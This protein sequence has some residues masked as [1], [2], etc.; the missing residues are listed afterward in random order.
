MF[1][2]FKQF[3]VETNAVAL[4]IA[5]VLGAAVA[6]LVTSL[7]D[8]L[9][10]PLLSLVLPGGDWRHWKLVMV[11]GTPG[12]D[13]TMVGEKAILTGQILGSALDFLIIAMIVY[14]VAVKLLK[15]ELK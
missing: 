9:I 12:P 13:G 8:G 3:L 15:I 10:M 5:V 2:K 11:H 1:E 14:M 7:T 6:K 4:A